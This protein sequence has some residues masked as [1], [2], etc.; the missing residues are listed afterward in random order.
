MIVISSMNTIFAT[1]L[2]SWQPSD[3]IW[4]VLIFKTTNLGRLYML[5]KFCS[6]CSKT[7][8]NYENRRV[9]CQL[10]STFCNFDWT[11][12]IKWIQV[13]YIFPGWEFPALSYSVCLKH[14]AQ[15]LVALQKDLSINV[16]FAQNA[17]PQ[18]QWGKS[19]MSLWL[20]KI[21]TFF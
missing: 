17:L 13:K 4:N 19:A 16:N 18:Q 3:H 14:A 10:L 6:C 9:F 11:K 7:R 21:S 5:T 15:L 2:L 1:N 12:N 8:K 20:N